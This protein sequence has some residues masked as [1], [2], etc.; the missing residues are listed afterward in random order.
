[1]EVKN[2]NFLALSVFTKASAK[3]IIG[4]REFIMKPLVP[5]KIRELIQLLESGGKELAS[6]EEINTSIGY[7]ITKMIEIFP[8]L[9][10]EN[11]TQEFIDNNMSIPVCME[12]WEYFVKI[13]RLEGL[14]PFFQQAVKITAN[15]ILSKEKKA[16]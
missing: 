15:P 1:M 9:F 4:E 13:N 12:I 3:F 5:R 7:I 14:I 2:D 10:N 16:D 6:L 11:I 8:I